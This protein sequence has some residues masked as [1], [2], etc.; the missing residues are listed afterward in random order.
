MPSYR[1]Q[2]LECGKT[3]I[4]VEI[5]SG[6]ICNC[7]PPKRI[8]G[9]KMREVIIERK[10]LSDELLTEISAKEAPKLRDSL[11]RRWGINNKSHKSHGSNFS[12][13][14]T[15]VNLIED[16]TSPVQGGLIAVVR[17]AIIEDYG[18]DYITGEMV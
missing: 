11:C 4:G 8:K 16:I 17:A 3:H 1:Y 15:L 2:C 18:Y 14:Q 5:V 7:H 10:P 13:N 9:M 6:M 12:S